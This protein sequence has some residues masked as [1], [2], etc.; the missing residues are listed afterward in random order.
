LPPNAKF[1]SPAPLGL[2]KNE[3]NFAHTRPKGDMSVPSTYQRSKST[4]YQ[5]GR[6]RAIRLPLPFCVSEGGLLFLRGPNCKLNQNRTK[7]K[8][9]LVPNGTWIFKLHIVQFL[10]WY[11]AYA[12]TRQLARAQSGNQ[13]RPRRGHQTRPSTFVYFSSTH[14]DALSKPVS[15][16]VQQGR[17]SSRSQ[18]STGTLLAS[19]RN[20][21]LA[22]LE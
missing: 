2:I 19:I 1:R 17:L 10:E 21:S 5:V 4:S 3:Y 16:S 8:V 13:P 18:L 12:V 20:L 14:A 7:R 11:C 9:P 22:C 6:R 15:S